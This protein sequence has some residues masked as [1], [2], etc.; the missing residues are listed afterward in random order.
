[1]IL[2]SGQVEFPLSV[3]FKEVALVYTVISVVSSLYLY[4]VLL[5]NLFYTKASCFNMR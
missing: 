4:C 3:L 5:D 1:M 2:L